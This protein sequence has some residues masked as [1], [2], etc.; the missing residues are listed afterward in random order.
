M[1]NTTLIVVLFVIGVLFGI[2][3]FGMVLRLYQREKG[4]KGSSEDS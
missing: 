4:G 2:V 1:D 3:A